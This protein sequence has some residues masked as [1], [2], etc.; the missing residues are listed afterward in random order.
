[1]LN[2]KELMK[3]LSFMMEALS[4]PSETYNVDLAMIAVS[5]AL[6]VTI[7][8]IKSDRRFTDLSEARFILFFLIKNNTE[9]TLREIGN[10]FGG[11]DHSTVLNGIG[12]YEELVYAKDKQFLTKINKVQMELGGRICV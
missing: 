2:T 10:L 9:L 3:E 1:M 8:D 5:I 4:E 11:R 7:E 6:E 12:R